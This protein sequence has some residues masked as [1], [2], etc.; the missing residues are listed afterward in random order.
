V[1]VSRAAFLR[2]CGLAVLAPGIDAGWLRAA[3]VARLPLETTSAAAFQ[4]F[5]NTTFVIAPAGAA[6]VPMVLAAV[7]DG[8]R[9]AR[10]EQYS[11]IFHAPQDDGALH[12]T[13]RVEHAVLPPFDLFIVPLRSAGN[14]HAVYQAC[15][16]RLAGAERHGR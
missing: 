4:P 3:A 5:V 13:H 9:D 2:T 16:S 7:T 12:G 15:L 6:P 10:V 11:L 14:S 8:P 1:A